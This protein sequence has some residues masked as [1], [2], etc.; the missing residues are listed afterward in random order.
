MNLVDVGRLREI[1]EV[2]FPDIV[3]EAIV[4]FANEL[5]IILKDGSFVDAWFSLKIAGRYSY[6]WERR[7]IDR[8]IFRHDNAPHKGWQFV[9][10]FPKHFHDGGEEIVSESRISDAPEEALRE[11]LS[12]VREKMTP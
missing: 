8:R 10:T 12:F 11:Y 7:G 9:A 1:A 5:R 4:P 2:E 3:E 6:H